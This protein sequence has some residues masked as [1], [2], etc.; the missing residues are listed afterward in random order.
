MIDEPIQLNEMTS[1]DENL[2]NIKR[3]RSMSKSN[4][5]SFDIEQ[6]VKPTKSKKKVIV[7]N[8]FLQK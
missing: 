1:D 2:Q 5:K 3:Q 8:V 4:N 6:P 7:N